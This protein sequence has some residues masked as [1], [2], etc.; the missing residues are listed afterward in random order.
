MPTIEIISLDSRNLGTNQRDFDVAIIEENE[1]IS[2]RGLFC[3]FLKKY[4]GTIL[5]IGNPEFKQNKDGGFF[6]GDLIDWEFDFQ[7]NF[8]FLEKYKPD[9]AKL[10]EVA[11]ENSPN[12]QTFFLTDIQAN[13]PKPKYRRI[14]S[15]TNF[16]KLYEHEGL[17]WNTLY[18]INVE[19]LKNSLYSE[20]DGI[21]WNFE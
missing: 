1:L 19:F 21:L 10:L 7:G 18:A 14:S 9:F 15:L 4:Q 17:E 6:G 8:K 2:H 16:W 13:N 12:K 11:I 5:H 3:Q 20:I